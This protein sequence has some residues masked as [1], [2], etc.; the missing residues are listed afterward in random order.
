M[1]LFLVSLACGFGWTVGPSLAACPS[2][3]TDGGVLVG[4]ETR[5]GY[6]RAA[7]LAVRAA[8]DAEEPILNDSRC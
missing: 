5:E 3:G 1:A 7:A 4:L 2:V 8:F 6:L